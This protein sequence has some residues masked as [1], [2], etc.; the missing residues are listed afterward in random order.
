MNRSVLYTLCLV[1]TIAAIMLVG[2]QKST[3]TGNAVVDT[4]VPTETPTSPEVTAAVTEEPTAQ[5]LPAENTAYSAEPVMDGD[6]KVFTIKANN[7]RFEPYTLTVKKGDKV[8]MLVTAEDRTY[9]FQLAEFHVKGVVEQGQTITVDFTAN[10]ADKF[11]IFSRREWNGGKLD[12][13]GE[14]VVEVQ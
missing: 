9:N 4:N 2:C 10:M 1:L 3:V 8:R 13:L 7:M 12:R 14:L 11:A 6:V 5:E